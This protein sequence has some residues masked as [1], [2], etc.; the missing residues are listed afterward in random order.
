MVRVSLNAVWERQPK[1]VSA[2]PAEAELPP[3]DFAAGY[4]GE[5]LIGM[6]I[7]H[8]NRRSCVNGK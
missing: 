3:D 1:K 8:A 5:E 7:L 2:R 4:R 6:T